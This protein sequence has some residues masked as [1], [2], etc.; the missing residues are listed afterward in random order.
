MKVV[1]ACAGTGGHINPAIAIAKYILKNDSKSDILFIGTFDGLENDLVKNAGF[2]IKPIRTGKLRRSLTLKNFSEITKAILG[3]KDAKKILK[4]FNPDIV[5]GTGG[6]ICM[7]V[8]SAAKSLKIPYMLH[9]SNAFP[10]VSVKLLSKNAAR[11]FVAFEDARMRLKN[12]K[13]IVLSGTPTKFTKEEYDALD[14]SKCIKEMNLS[15]YKKILLVTGGSQGARKFSNVILE[16][17]ENYQR[18]DLFVVLVT[19]DKNYNE[20]LQ[21]KNE[22]EN[23]LNKKLD[24]YIKIEKF[25]FD[26]EKMYKVADICMTRAGAMTITELALTNK[27]SI[28]VPYPYAAENHQFYNAKVLENIGLGKIIED[29]DLNIEKLNFTINELM[30]VSQIELEK[31]DL[32]CKVDSEKIIYENILKVIKK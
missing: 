6:Y 21:K 24:D 25:V 7:P 22:I 8:M 1:F 18:D 14:K 32:L 3:K 5:I 13:N 30:N 19:G 2:R 10:G 4:E 15:K 20:I 12:R 31:S 29:K 27:A 28:L 11:V 17:L 23:K 16:Y 26:M 9:E